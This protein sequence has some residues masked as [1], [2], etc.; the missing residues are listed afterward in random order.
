MA[1]YFWLC[2]TNPRQLMLASSLFSM[3]FFQDESISLSYAVLLDPAL[4]CRPP[5]HIRTDE[6]AEKIYTEGRGFLRT[7]KHLGT[8]SVR[9][10]RQT[11][12]MKPKFHATSLAT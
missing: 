7:F 2:E 12:L 11:F 3:S 9:Q 5:K 4:F 10:N 6:A 8:I 1:R